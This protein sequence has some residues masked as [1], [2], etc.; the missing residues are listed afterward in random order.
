M[1]RTPVTISKRIPPTS[2]SNVTRSSTW[3]TERAGGQENRRGSTDH[4]LASTTGITTRP[5]PT[6]RPWL[7][8]YSHDGRVGQSKLGSLSQPTS[9]GMA[10]PN[11]A[12]EAIWDSKPV[13]ITIGKTTS[14]V[15]PKTDVNH[16]PRN[17][18]RHRIRESPGGGGFPSDTHST[19]A[20]P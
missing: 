12:P 4:N 16:G 20:H 2:M 10:C 17:G 9:K 15:A 11:S 3:A 6:C 18:L 5:K 7:S 19:A 1:L 8:R 13:T 14:S